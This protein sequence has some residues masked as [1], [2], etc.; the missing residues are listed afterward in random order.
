MIRSMFSV[1]SSRI[2]IP[3]ESGD[4]PHTLRWKNIENMY[5]PRERG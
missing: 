2:S 1:P 4:D 5:S 3:R